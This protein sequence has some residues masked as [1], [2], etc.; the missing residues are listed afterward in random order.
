MSP[1]LTQTLQ[2]CYP[3]IMA[4]T[5]ILVL[6]AAAITGVG[7][8][9]WRTFRGPASNLRMLALRLLAV[10]VV[11]AAM[12]TFSAWKLS[13]ARTFQLLGQIV[14]RVETD[15]RVVALTFDDGPSGQFTGSRPP[16]FG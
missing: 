11:A 12:V 6:A 7:L 14:P 15:H 4:E 10:A 8:L 9:A 5:V 16:R 13:K 3:G 1:G 2:A